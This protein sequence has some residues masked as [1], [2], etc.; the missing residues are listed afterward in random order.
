MMSIYGF[1]LL[2]MCVVAAVAT[3]AVVEKVGGDSRTSP[4]SPDLMTAPVPA[5]RNYLAKDPVC[6]EDI[7]R[8]CDKSILHNNFAVLDCAQNSKKDEF[9]DLSVGCQH[10]LWDFKH[11]LTKDDRFVEAAKQVCGR[12]MEKFPECSPDKNMAGHTLSCLM[13]VQENITS[14]QCKQFLTK[15]ENIVFSD[16]RLIY[17]FTLACDGDIQRQS[18]GRLDGGTEDAVPHSQGATIECLSKGAGELSAPCQHE[19]LRIAEIQSEDFHLDRVLFFAC[20]EDRERLC[21]NIQ[22]GDGRVYRCLMQHKGDKDMSHDCYEQL[23]RRQKLVMLDYKVSRGMAKSCREDIR[24]YRCRE[25][26]SKNREIRLAQILV[27]L[28][29]AQH[30][31]YPVAGE[32]QAEMLDHRRS[33]LEDYRLSANV[34]H[35]CEEDIRKFCNERLEVN[36]RTIHCLMDHARPTTR[37]KK[38]ISESCKRE[39]EELV[40]QTD[41]GEDWRADPALKEACQPVVDVGCKNLRAGEGRVLSCLMDNIG[42]DHMTEDCEEHLLQI[43]YFVARDYRLDPK[44][45]QNCHEDARTFCS[46]SENWATDPQEMGPKRG[47]LLPCLFRYTFHPL[48]DRKM[49][50]ACVREVR[51]VMRQRAVSVDLHP[52]IEV[53]CV[54]DLADRCL[55]KVK[56]GEE[57]VCLQDNLES[58]SAD[59]K[60]AIRNYT[61]EQAEHAELNTLLYKACE[62]FAKKYCED[63]MTN[64]VD[65]GDIMQCLL[66]HKNDYAIRSES[67]CRAGLE[68]F[69]LISLKDY[70]FSFKLKEACKKDVVEL[71]KASTTK[72]EVVSCL[73]LAVRDDTLADRPQRVSKECRHQLR[74]ELIQRNEDIHL[75]PELERAC[76]IDLKKFCPVV[77]SGNA[78]VLECLKDFQRSLSPDCYTKVFNRQREEMLDNGVDYTLMT[79]C[80]RM[81]KV[82][83]DGDDTVNALAC[84]KQNKA[85]PKFDPVC[86]GVVVRRMAQQNMDY[87]LNPALRKACLPD[88]QKFCH[89]VLTP[90]SENDDHAYEG[91]VISCL[92]DRFQGRRLRPLCEKEI[93]S[94][95]SEAQ[96]DVRQDPILSEA[97]K[98]EIKMLCPDQDDEQGGGQVEECLKVKFQNTL[99]KNPR[100]RQ[101]VAKLI[102]EG[103]ADIHVDP[104][105]FKACAMDIQHFCASIPPGQGRQMKCLMDAAQSTA[106]AQQLQEHCRS[107]LNKR[108][109]MFEFARKEAPPENVQDVMDQIVSSPSRNYFAVVGLAIVGSIFIGGLFCGRVTKRVHYDIKRK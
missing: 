37:K 58:L 77:S 82:F 83:C 44:L 69:Q 52:E 26:T 100:C 34:V 105:L 73:S 74:V 91:K 20:R 11:N 59:C 93:S 78:Q 49:S 38:R 102:Q 7:A 76:K 106:T 92:K 5:P 71:C 67:K 87:R 109:Q 1:V 107:M 3:A 29:N 46:A 108:L 54:V 94:I 72:T 80:K 45:Y 81:L 70:R 53:A 8:I 99:I 42:T 2:R 33:L 22:A 39:L 79:A 62:P 10:L 36:G 97:C 43:Q 6:A 60:N 13:D 101:Q 4:E 65:Q 16:Y 55:E 66:Q 17:K 98:D 19:I 61:E 48:V 9:S 31:G 18:C 25:D 15:M 63:I 86:R 90:N 32:C 14:L 57:I 104:L 41:A 28:E 40:A 51:R 88:I 21:L 47:P 103:S 12:D 50:S 96:L 30:K 64:D 23:T 75:D 27:C 95:I 68:H 84:L 35:A 89:K 56:K 85:D 24:A